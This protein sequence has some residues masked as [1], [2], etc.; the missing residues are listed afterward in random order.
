MRL[1]VI[2]CSPAWPNPGQA[3]AGYL[4]EGPGKLLLDCGPGVLSRLRAREGGWPE[5]D[6]IVREAMTTRLRPFCLAS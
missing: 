1:T 2:G 6:A 4:V 5:V 3:N